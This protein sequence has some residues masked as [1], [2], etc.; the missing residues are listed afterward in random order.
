MGEWGIIVSAER[1]KD[2]GESQEFRLSQDKKGRLSLSFTA[3]ALL[4]LLTA[5]SGA[6][7]TVNTYQGHQQVTLLQ[8]QVD[9]MQANELARE[10]RSDEMQAK[11]DNLLDGLNTLK[12][13]MRAQGEKLNLTYDLVQRMDADQRSG[14][15]A[16]IR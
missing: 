6:W 16:R 14:R 2:T 5:A 13:D 3:K 7:M 15:S 10:R 9:T 4:G 1:L 12:G 11:F 8:K